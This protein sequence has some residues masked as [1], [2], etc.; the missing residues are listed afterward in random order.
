MLHLTLRTILRIGGRL[1][2][3]AW[4][5]VMLEYATR[6]DFGFGVAVGI[7]LGLVLGSICEHGPLSGISAWLATPFN[8]AKVEYEQATAPARKAAAQ[9]AVDEVVARLTTKSDA[10]PPS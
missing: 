7:V 4:G 10:H 1:L 2:A 8:E 5:L 3:I 6:G 9:R